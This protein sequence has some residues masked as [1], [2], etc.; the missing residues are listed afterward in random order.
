MRNKDQKDG[1]AQ[2]DSWLLK[3]DND[4]S[5]DKTLVTLGVQTIDL[6]ENVENDSAKDDIENVDK[7]VDKEV[8]Q[9]P[10]IKD[11]E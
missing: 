8:G 7:A 6:D 4:T 5:K 10:P 1:V 9:D 11:S 3:Q 2:K